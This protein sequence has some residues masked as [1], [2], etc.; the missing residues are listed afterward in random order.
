MTTRR[1]LIALA[2]T[3]GAVLGPAVPAAAH[4]DRVT[5]MDR[6]CWLASDG[7]KATCTRFGR[8]VTYWAGYE[9]KLIVRNG[10]IW[11]LHYVPDPALE[12]TA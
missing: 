12:G 7:S 8:Q 10:Y 9:H 2:L 11:R 6:T 1:T 5:P 3:L 4:D